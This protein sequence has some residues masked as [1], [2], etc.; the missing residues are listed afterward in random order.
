MSALS[1]DPGGEPSSAA[2]LTYEEISRHT[3]PQD[4]WIVVN[5]KAYDVTDFLDDHPGGPAVVLEA[6]GVDST[7]AFLEAHPEDIMKLTLGPAGLAKSLV[8]PVDM[9]SMPLH[10]KKAEPGKKE[11]AAGDGLEDADGI[12]PLGAILNLHDMEA[13]AQRVMV[14]KGKKHA[15]D[16]YSSGADDE[17]T[18][19]DNVNAFQRIWLKPR[20]LVNVAEVD[21]S[22]SILGHSCKLPI[23]LSAV[24]MCG[25]GHEE[26]EISWVRAAERAGVL[27]MVPNL[28]SK[29]FDDI[30]AARGPGQVV[31]LQIYVNPDRSVVLEQIRSCEKHGVKALCITVDSA[32]AGKRERDLR[33]KLAMQLGREK[34]QA[35]AAKGTPARKAGSYANRD[36][37]LDWGDIAWFRKQTSIPIV[38][39]GVQ[40]ADDAVLAAKAGAAGVVLSNHG[41]RNCDTSRSGIEVLPEVI[42]ALKEEGLR[43]QLEVW[44][45]GGVRRGTD[46][47]KAICMGADAVGLGKP[48]V[49]SMSAYGEDGIVKMLDTLKEELEK[50]MRL[51]GTPTLADLN[52]R[53]VDARSV[54][55]HTDVAPIPPS[56]YAYEPPAKSVRSPAFPSMPQERDKIQAEIA[57]LT[58]ALHKLERADGSGGRYAIADTARV[59][60]KLLKVM[61]VSVLST[62][63]A[64]SYSGSLHRSALFL[65]VFLVVHMGGN[66]T[67]LFGRDAYNSYGHHLNSMPFIRVIELYLAVGMVVHLFAAAHFTV[68]KRKAIKKGPLTTGLLALTGTILLAFVVLHLKAFRFSTSTRRWRHPDALANAPSDRDLYYLMLEL[69]EQPAQVMFYVSAIVAVG[70]HLHRGWSKTVLKMVLRKTHPPALLFF[71]PFFGKLEK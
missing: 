56:P 36:P 49:F 57:K 44:V 59:F 38:I 29:S 8:G 51:C 5:G 33:N 47:L 20:I 69:F 17:L 3:T 12:P 34:Q 6:A 30:L 37:G 23:Y 14:A 24:A 2:L 18:Y 13:V 50:C 11:E 55:R 66:L 26:G 54:G 62:V 15:W 16:Y 10:A 32:V 4:C 68:N 27:F 39:K 43:D 21:T 7:A 52:P 31:F 40:T 48:A 58:Q 25:M 45:D 61:L 60:V 71:L 19:N 63:F 42:E 28:S 64:T 22:C 46:V 53:L 65:L 67:A 1:E 41:G 70:V 35:A 9:S